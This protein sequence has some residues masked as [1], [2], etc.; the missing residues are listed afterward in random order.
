MKH[1]RVLI[2]MV[3]GLGLALALLW[4]LRGPSG[5]VLAR[6][7]LAPV[8]PSLARQH[9]SAVIT[10]GLI[11][12]LTG[13]PLDEIFVYAYQ[14]ATVTQIP[15]QIDERDADGTYVAVEDGQLDL[16]DE[17]VFMAMD[18][19]GWVDHPL[20][21]A[22]GV[23]ISP[24]YVITLT[25]PISDTR[26]WAYVF[27]SAAL[28]RTF[29]ADYVSYDDGDDRITSP[30]RYAL[31]FDA[32]CGFMDYLS[33]GDGSPNLLDRS[34]VRV[35]GTLE[36]PIGPIPFSA[37]EEDITQ[38]AVH[39]LDGPVRVTRVS[40][41]TQPGVG[42]SVQDI[43]VLFAYRTV[44]VRPAT[45]AVLGTPVQVNHARTSLDWSER[46]A[47]TTYY[48]ANNPAGVAV[49]GSP[50][51]IALTP[52][53]RWTQVTAVTGTVV[54]VSKIPDGLGGTRST[55]YRDDS[56]IDS[57]DTGDQRSYGDAGFQVDDPNPGTYVA[58]G[59]IYFLTGTAGNVGAAYVDYYDVPLQVSVATVTPVW[60]I[61]LPV[62]IK[63]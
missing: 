41:S 29:T 9:A 50:D 55:Y 44:V 11:S 31:G 38:D 43:A 6:S 56:A 20:L 22:G 32:T 17:L 30:G 34:K 16:N 51:V 53:T 13:C 18:G 28:S 33:L 25:D 23:S 24:V 52:P 1:S 5:P 57:D 59:H 54:S 26:A 47:G 36:T 45:I 58:L 19:G 35:A 62:V 48:D 7:D 60:Y 37:N 39:V 21:D 46:A 3:L 42:G 2:T 8:P 27:C 10:G 40:T 4:V 12:D 63:E 15:A 49:N 61:Y 14:G